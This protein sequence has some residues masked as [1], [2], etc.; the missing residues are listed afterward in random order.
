MRWS[1]LDPVAFP[2]SPCPNLTRLRVCLCLLCS[3]LARIADS[4]DHVFP[5]NDGFQALQG[6][7]HS[8]SRATCSGTAYSGPS[9]PRS[10]AQCPRCLSLRLVVLFLRHT[11]LY[12]FLSAVLHFSL[13]TF[14]PVSILLCQVF[15]LQW[16]TKKWKRVLPWQWA[17]LQAV[18]VLEALWPIAVL[19]SDLSFPSHDWLQPPLRPLQAQPLSPAHQRYFPPVAFSLGCPLMIIWTGVLESSLVI[20][21][22]L[23]F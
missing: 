6:I 17:R 10:A 7:I 14:T 3:Q 1:P 12:I 2:G 21:K 19:L 23:F 13:L 4:K 15:T 20:L 18:L 11:P 22:G 5:V 8:V 16:K 9:G